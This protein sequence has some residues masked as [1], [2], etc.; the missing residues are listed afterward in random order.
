MNTVT[1]YTVF[2]RAEPFSPDLGLGLEMVVNIEV[3][4]NAKIKPGFP[5]PLYDLFVSKFY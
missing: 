3:S 4:R 2:I 5:E 1:K